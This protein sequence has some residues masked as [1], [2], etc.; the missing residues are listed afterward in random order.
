MAL[1]GSV[2]HVSTGAVFARGRTPAV[3][4]TPRELPAS[5]F[6][7]AQLCCRHVIGLRNVDLRRRPRGRKLSLEEL[8]GSQKWR[9]FPPTTAAA[10]AAA[11][12][13]ALTAPRWALRNPKKI[14]GDVKW[15]RAEGC[16]LVMG[17]RSRSG[18]GR[19]QMGASHQRRLSP[20]AATALDGT[21]FSSFIL[22]LPDLSPFL[23][24]SIGGISFVLLR[25]FVYFRM[26]Y[27]TA[28]M[29]ARHV[30]RGGARVLD[31]NVAGGKNLYYLPKDVVQVIAVNPKASRQLLDNQAV[32]AGVPIVFEDMTASG[33]LDLPSNSVDAVVSI[34]ALCST[35]D[36]QNI[37][38]EAV[39]VL[40]PGKPIIFVENV[41]ASGGIVLAAQRALEAAHNLTG[42]GV[43]TVRNTLQEIKTVEELG[44]VESDMV[45]EFQDPHVVGIGIKKAA[46]VNTAPQTPTP[47]SSTKN[48]TTAPKKEVRKGG[49][50][51]ATSA[52]R[53][54][55]K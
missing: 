14:L 1:I 24:T 50:G 18:P 21:E 53:Q 36:V 8:C 48:K 9:S 43:H 3:E 27:V 54:T 10:A 7:G 25:L 23:V 26:Q 46:S 52:Q 32:Q 44:T 4:D 13:A 40:K 47:F 15:E 19:R 16:P 6:R 34:Y 45:A 29:L 33:A 12:A 20:A 39:R 17:I 49:F 30:P 37:L 22:N 31:L 41:A 38:K 5:S 42:W 51:S 11:A 28:A 55:K 35:P 2:A